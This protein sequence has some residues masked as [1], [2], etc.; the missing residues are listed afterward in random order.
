VLAQEL[1]IANRVFSH[2]AALSR[3]S[4]SG[5]GMVFRRGKNY[6]GNKEKLSG[7]GVPRIL[8]RPRNRR[9]V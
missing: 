4:G 8:F 5:I 7:G 9:I 2:Q 3:F 6:K 1:L